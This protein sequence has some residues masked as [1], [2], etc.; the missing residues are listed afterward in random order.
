MIPAR[1]GSKSVTRKNIRIMNG[2]PLLAFTAETALRA[3][4]L[5]RV[6]LST[7]DEE[8]AEVG[9]S[10]GLDVPF[11]R[12]LELA[13]DST[14]TLPVIRHALLALQEEGESY[15][16]VCLLQP[17]NPLRREQDIDGCVGLLN[18]SQATCVVSVLQVPHEY[19]PKWVFWRDEAGKMAISTGDAEP[20]T[21][22][23]DLPHAFYRDGSVYVTRTDTILIENSIYGHYLLG[24]EMEP[25]FSANIDTLEDWQRVQERLSAVKTEL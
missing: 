25:E 2:K 11:T 4:S 7:E 24:Y 22:R 16:A 10:C 17:T 8:I 20:V 15:D 14:P 1:G 12:P 3:R 23:Q 6:V 18:G 5:D 9:R 19:N 21:R 13:Q